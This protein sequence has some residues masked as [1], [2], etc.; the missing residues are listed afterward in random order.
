MALPLRATSKGDPSEPK[1]LD[2]RFAWRWAAR[3][4]CPLLTLFFL[5]P[6]ILWIVRGD[7]SSATIACTMTAGISAALAAPAWRR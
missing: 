5:G 7:W 6:L 4:V 1:S 3:I 2:R